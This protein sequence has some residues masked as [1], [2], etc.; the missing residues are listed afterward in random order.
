MKLKR[1]GD[2]LSSTMGRVIIAVVILVVVLGFIWI[3]KGRLGAIWGKLAR[4][5]RFGG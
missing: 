5:M 4:V 1:K 3:L 2:L